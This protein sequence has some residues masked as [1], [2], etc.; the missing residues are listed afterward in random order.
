[1]PFTLDRNK[2]VKCRCG[3]VMRQSRWMDHWRS[4]R[5]GAADGKV[6]PDDV[7]ALMASED[8]MDKMWQTHQGWLAEQ[9]GKGNPPTISPRS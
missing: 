7:A 3:A 9:R 6:T 8:E 1:M 5:M 2:I 4:C